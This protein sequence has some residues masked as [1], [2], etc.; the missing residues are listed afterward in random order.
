MQSRFV[1]RPSQTKRWSRNEAGAA[2]AKHDLF[3][4]KRL[5]KLV[6]SSSLEFSARSSLSFS[7]MDVD[8][9]WLVRCTRRLPHRRKKSREPEVVSI[10]K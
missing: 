10:T 2:I 8:C 5:Q 3:V 7:E 1:F 6:H 4:R 9:Q